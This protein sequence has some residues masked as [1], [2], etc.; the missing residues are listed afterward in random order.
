MI[1]FLTIPHLTSFSFESDVISELVTAH[2]VAYDGI[3]TMVTV[4]HSNCSRA[5]VE[6]YF[7]I[8]EGVDLMLSKRCPSE[9]A[10]N[11]SH[12]ARLR[13]GDRVV[14]LGFR[15]NVVDSV[16]RSWEGGIA[17]KVSDFRKGQCLAG[18]RNVTVLPDEFILNGHQI[19]GMSGGGC[20][21]GYGY[22]GVAHA[23]DEFGAALVIPESYVRSCIE[24]Y[25]ANLTR[26]EDCPGLKV[27]VPPKLS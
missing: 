2:S 14:A 13:E 26:I 27:I 23:V 22:L 16:M 7:L 5:G 24:K 17:G 21:N 11:I 3:A 18:E 10:M 12:A 6:E 9:F 8:C 19:P 1:D 15:H 20:L 4:A 25:R